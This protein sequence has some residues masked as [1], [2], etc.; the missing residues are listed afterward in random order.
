MS[1]ADRKH[2]AKPNGPAQN[3]EGRACRVEKMDS[4]QDVPMNKLESCQII[5]KSN[6]NARKAKKE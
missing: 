1:C 2:I 3:T 5:P 4:S 6:I